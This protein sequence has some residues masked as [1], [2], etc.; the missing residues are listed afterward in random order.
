MSVNE[1]T[2]DI[3]S[4]A[5][6]AHRALGPGLLESVYEECLCREL[7]LRKTRVDCG[8]AFSR[9]RG[10]AHPGRRGE[11]HDSSR[12]PREIPA[13]LGAESLRHGA[14]RYPIPNSSTRSSGVPHCLQMMA[15]QSPHTS[16]SWIATWQR[17]QYN[18]FAVG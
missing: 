5:I 10:L 11:I 18:S 9:R 12:R 4:A 7:N 6:E 15:A 16:G 8:S 2:H 14:D 1:I 17:G 13:H 3:I